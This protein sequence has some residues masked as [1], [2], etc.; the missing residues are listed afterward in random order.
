MPEIPPGALIPQDHLSRT[1]PA[2][3]F[4]FTANGKE[5]AL[6]DANEGTQLKIPGRIMRAAAL[7]EPMGEIGLIFGSLEA[8]G[9]PQETLDA[10]YSLPFDELSAIY[11][12]WASHRSTPEAASLGESGGS[13]T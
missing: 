9:A 3:P 4:T 7:K 12:G 13:P 8:S 2:G 5:Y 10:L 11:A 1:E 6:P